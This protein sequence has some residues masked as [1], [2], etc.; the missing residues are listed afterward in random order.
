MTR[1]CRYEGCP[2]SLHV[3]I[4]APTGPLPL[5]PTLQRRGRFTIASLSLSLEAFFFSFSSFQICLP[6]SYK[7]LFF[8]L[9][10]Y[11]WQSIVHSKPFGGFGSIVSRFLSLP[12]FLFIF[13][14]WDKKTLLEFGSTRFCFY[15]KKMMNC[16]DWF[17]VHK[18][19]NCRFQLFL[20]I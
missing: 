9:S 15:Y 11:L 14:K 7:G 4:P 10:V 3:C 8:S 19:C 20:S 13:S 6:S 1:T 16:L 17:L 18:M 12:P 5:S 2:S